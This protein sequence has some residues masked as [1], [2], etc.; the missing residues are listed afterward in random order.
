ME[1]SVPTGWYQSHISY[2]N[3]TNHTVNMSAAFIPGLFLALIKSDYCA[4]GATTMHVDNQ[5][6]FME[7]IQDD[8]Y[9]VNG[10]L[11]KLKVRT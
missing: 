8:Q 11:K 1:T 5:D 6:L 2:Q 4:W 3:A 9:L 10:E 7:T